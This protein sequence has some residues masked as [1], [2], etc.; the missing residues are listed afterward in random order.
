MHDS[1]KKDNIH[2][3]GG[4]FNLCIQ[5]I[6]VI[7]IEEGMKFCL[8]ILCFI[9]QIDLYEKNAGIYLELDENNKILTA[10]TE[11]EKVDPIIQINNNEKNIQLK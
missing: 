11:M 7:K 8:N 3:T 5:F 4:V 1:S 6:P 10:T 9:N 2:I